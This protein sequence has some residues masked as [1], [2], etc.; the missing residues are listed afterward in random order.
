MN[1]IILHLTVLHVILQDLPLWLFP[2][3]LNSSIHF[4]SKWHCLFGFLRGG[5]EGPSDSAIVV[6]GTLTLQTA[7]KLATKKYFPSEEPPGSLSHVI[8]MMFVCTKYLCIC[9]CDQ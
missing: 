2:I 1:I 7:R 6:R 4:S 5:V 8:I 3:P 9:T